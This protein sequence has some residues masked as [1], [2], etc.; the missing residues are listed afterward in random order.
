LLEAAGLCRVDDVRLL[1]VPARSCDVGGPLGHEKLAPVVSLFTVEG[2]DDAIA[3][4]KRLLDE[5]G[6]GHTSIVHTQ[7]REVIDRFAREMRASRILINAPGMQGSIGIGTGLA[8]SLT[9][10]TGTF[11]GTSTT[12]NVTFRHLS[13]IKRLAYP[14]A[15][16]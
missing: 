13:N 12:D 15:A 10:G 16:A 7:D 3:L 11:G 9:L 8:T 5:D 2:D 4:C 1:L 6:S 14:E